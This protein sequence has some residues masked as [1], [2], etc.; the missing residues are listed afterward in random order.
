MPRELTAA[1]P[2]SLP[3]FSVALGCAN[4]VGGLVD[5]CGGTAGLLRGVTGGGIL[6][7]V[8]HYDSVRGLVA[9]FSAATNSVFT[10]TII[11]LNKEIYGLSLKIARLILT[12]NI[13]I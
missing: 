12:V 9:V 2:L 5:G 10:S 11:I 1:A 3:V 8:E 6:V 7:P 4:G 13:K